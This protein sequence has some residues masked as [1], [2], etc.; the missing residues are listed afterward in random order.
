MKNGKTKQPFVLLGAKVPCEIRDFL[1]R[2]AA[3]EER[4]ISQVTARL[5]ASHPVIKKALRENKTA[6]AI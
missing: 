4:S 1:E 3:D 2:Q 6:K 5:L